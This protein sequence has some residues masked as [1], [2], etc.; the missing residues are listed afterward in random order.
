MFVWVGV[1]VQVDDAVSTEVEQTVVSLS[2]AK[3]DEVRT[4]K[5]M[6]DN[7][8]RRILTLSQLQG[9]VKTILRTWYCCSS[10]R[11]ANPMHHTCIRKVL[12]RMGCG[13][14]MYRICLEVLPLRPRN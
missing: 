6:A 12:L 9:K 11:N 13:Y 8:V 5:N 7:N 10:Y 1:L 4:T 14:T 3:M 2:A